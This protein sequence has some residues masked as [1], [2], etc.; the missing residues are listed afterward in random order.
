MVEQHNTFSALGEHVR[1]AAAC[2]GCCRHCLAVAVRRMV[3]NQRVCSEIR[4]S[5]LLS[6]AR[7]RVSVF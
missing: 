3:L 4:L 1:R 7:E 6:G 2:P 5:V